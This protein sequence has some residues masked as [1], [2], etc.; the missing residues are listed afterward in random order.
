MKKVILSALLAFAYSW[1][2]AQIYAGND[3]AVCNS[4]SVTLNATVTGSYGTTNY[5]FA[6]IP[7]APYPATGTIPT[8]TWGPAFDNCDDCVTNALPIGFNFCFLGQ[9]HTQFYIGTNG[10]ISFSPQPTTYTSAT[11]PSTNPSVPKDCIMGPWE[12]WYPGGGGNGG[13]VVYQTVGTAPNRK[14][15]V[16]WVNCPMFS[17]TNLT[18]N[19]QIVLHE[20]TNMIENFLTNIPNCPSWAGGTATQGV[21]EGTGTIAY[22]VPGR[23]STQWTANNEGWQFAPSGIVWYQNSIS[24]ANQVG[25]GPTVTVTPATTTSYIAEITICGGQTYTDT[26]VVTI[27]QLTPSYSQ[28]NISCFGGNDGFASASAS[29]PAGPWSYVWTDANGNTVQTTNNIS[30]PDTLNNL[31]AGT[32]AVTITN[33]I[34]CVATHTFTLTEPAAPLAATMALVNDSCSGA[35]DAVATVTAAGGTAPYAYSWTTTPV[36]TSNQATGLGSGTYTVTVT[37]SKGCTQT[38]TVTVFK[39]PAPVAD[40]SFA[41]AVISLFDP[42]C[43]FTDESTNAV[44]WNWNFGDGDTTSAQNPTHT[45][46]AEGTYPV[47]LTVTNAI[48][49]TNTVVIPVKVEDF[50]TLY[51]PNSFTPNGDG[52][53]DQFGAYGSGIDETTFEIRIFTR[54]GDQVYTTNDIHEWWNGSYKNI[55]DKV[56]EGVYVYVVRFKDFKKIPHKVMGH[57]TVLR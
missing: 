3:T 46:D 32:Y 14:L 15:V 55:G 31:P 1:S 29:G 49:C 54:W 47:T 4:S 22:T 39:D 10:W 45:Y 21:H 28:G 41:P 24:T 33:Q 43:T 40:F 2:S 30:T 23:N 12:D 42:L 57:V 53:N 27:G 56:E 35:P 52:K 37:D 5:S 34:G 8:S 36:Q 7:Y 17:C 20:T 19:F 25:I 18:G 16:S 48:G 26:V 9:N 11:I 13:Q 44:T 6:Q 50:Y 51:L 38:Q